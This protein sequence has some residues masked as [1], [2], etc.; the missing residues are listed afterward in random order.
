[1]NRR[2]LIEL[3]GCAAL[4]NERLPNVCYGSGT[5]GSSRRKSDHVCYAPQAEVIS[6][7]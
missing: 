7:H 5:T 4:T 2:T 6:E 1:M 3:S